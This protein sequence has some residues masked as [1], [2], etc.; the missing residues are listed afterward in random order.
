MENG[1]REVGGEHGR[2]KKRRSVKG[3][4]EIDEKMKN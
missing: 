4:R 2:W 1:K 3:E